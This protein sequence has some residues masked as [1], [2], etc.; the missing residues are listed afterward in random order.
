MNENDL[1]SLFKQANYYSN[2]HLSDDIWY[3]ICSKK[4]RISQ[5]K[6]WL[7]VSLNILSFLGLIFIIK[8]ITSQL[9]QSGF[10]EYVSLALS[11]GNIFIY[12]KEFMLSVTE[13]LPLMSITLSFLFLFLF[14]VSM[15]HIIGYRSKSSLLIS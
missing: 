14:F 7:Y 4:D 5:I 3:V 1:K 2:V 11:V 6:A 10:Y 15:K 13:S 12:W 8:D 9:A